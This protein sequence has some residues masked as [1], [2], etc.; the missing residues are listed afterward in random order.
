VPALV[1]YTVNKRVGDPVWLKRQGGA[2]DRLWETRSQQVLQRQ[3]RARR[4][5][6]PGGSLQTALRE[7]NGERVQGLSG[8]GKDDITGK[9]FDAVRTDRMKRYRKM[10]LGAFLK[11]DPVT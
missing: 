7:L 3:G 1:F 9:T 8:K 4:S 10:V 6:L 5:R 11:V 2:G